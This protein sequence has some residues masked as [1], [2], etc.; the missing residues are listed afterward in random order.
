MGLEEGFLQQP[1]K[2]T[3]GKTEGGQE[4]SKDA[5]DALSEKEWG[6]LLQLNRISPVEFFSKLKN[7]N[8]QKITSVV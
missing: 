6:E 1:Q 2:E 3:E 4:G 5:G 7:G 8:F